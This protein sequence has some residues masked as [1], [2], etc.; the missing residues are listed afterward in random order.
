MT[1]SLAE[2]ECVQKNSICLLDESAVEAMYE[3]LAADITVEC[4]CWHSFNVQEAH[5]LFD[6]APRCAIP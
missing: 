5:Y 6:A 3:K 4:V 2:I 1:V